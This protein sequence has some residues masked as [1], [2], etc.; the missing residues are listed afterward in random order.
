MKPSRNRE[1]KALALFV[2]AVMVLLILVIISSK[3]SLESPDEALLL[4]RTQE[5]LS[6]VSAVKEATQLI[7]FNEQDYII[8]GE[9]ARLKERDAAVSVRAKFL[10]R[11]K[12][13]T[14]D[15]PRNQLDWARMRELTD[16]LLVITDRQALLRKTESFAAAR[17]P[18]R[19]LRAR[20]FE[21][22][23]EI[24]QE[25]QR[26]LVR[27]DAKQEARRN[28]VIGGGALTFL[29]LFAVLSLNYFMM[30]RQLRLNAVS[31]RLLDDAAD[32]TRA[33]LDTVVDGIITID[34]RGIV[35]TINPAT[36][37][38]FGYTAAEIIGQNVKML[39]PEPYR[40]E[41]DG[42][43]ENYRTT[44]TARII[45]SGR[46]V[47]GRRKDGS[48]FPLE[49][50]VSP[51]LVSSKRHFTGIVHDITARKQAEDQINSFFEL[52]LDMMCIAGADGY[53]KRVNAAFTQMLGLTTRE[54]LARPFLDFVHADDRD[55]TSAVARQVSTG[56]KVM[57][58]EN[59]FLHKDGSSRDLSWMV[60]PQENGLMF[61]T[62]RDVT[63]SKRVEQTILAAKNA[64]EQAN[65][66]K[67]AFLS[68]MSHEIR[69]PLGGLLG[70]LELLSL[71]PLDPEQSDTL[72]TARN[73]GNSLLRILND[74]LDWSKIGEGKLELA[75]QA[76]SIAG[77]VAE[78]MSIYSHLAVRDNV[79]LTQQVDPRLSPAHMVD[80][81]RLAQVLNN[82][83]SNAIKFSRGGRVD[84]RAE[85]IDCREGAEQLRLS[86][87]DTGIGIAPDVQQRLF[88]FYGQG[89]VD[90]ASLYGGTGL[91]LAICHGLAELMGGCLALE[92]AVGRGS[93]FSI[94]LTL[95]VT[96]AAVTNKLALLQSEIAAMMPAQRAG[97][98]AE[99]ASAPSVVDMVSPADAPLIL[100]A[101][102]NQVLRNLIVCQLEILGLRA[103]TAEDGQAALQLWRNGRF[104]LV[105]TD[106]HM[107]LMDGFALTRAI[108]KIEADEA[109]ERTPVLAWSATALQE[110]IANS[111]S[112][113]IDEFMV[114]PVDLPR[115]KQVLTKWLPIAAVVDVRA[116][117]APRTAGP[118]AL[119][120]N[121]L[122]ALVG[123]DQSII[124]EFLQ[125][126]GTSLVTTATELR[127]ACQRGQAAVAGASAHKLKS[128][129]SCV[130]A[131]RLG[132]LCAEIE[133]AGET[134]D[135]KA[136]GILMP[137]FE[138]EVVAV[139]ECLHSLL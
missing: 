107:P 112:A 38:L 72:L 60:V 118:R 73:A 55:V 127:T 12:E 83:V 4:A 58:F 117:L 2:T 92:S 15:N 57:H 46:E 30:L 40:S 86:V 65:R 34:E 54:M 122:K 17:V 98:A 25:E 114:K 62:A 76:T 3:I 31:R 138:Q 19:E 129:A 7:V 101:E 5:L 29:L 6:N 121:V 21:I 131:P 120:V 27:H 139:E 82:F 133:R 93:T 28:L 111:R 97:G 53:F 51:T 77:L 41:H 59:R 94:T 20:L 36:E 106:Y 91:G 52:S 70:S 13:Q 64:A 67:N 9:V 42:Y 136:L 24:E 123:D 81:M 113:G 130:G 90:T 14:D 132:D 104:A 100:V 134:G 48:T 69:T 137:G 10:R 78:V 96:T 71:T 110:E 50:A 37:R 32:R 128:L 108:R 79:T 61:A 16:E 125:V 88:Q 119:D 45:G 47:I 116:A 103:E 49:L 66:S 74:I 44:G 43:L 22:L 35:D 8:S 75:P 80:P 99:A 11:I 95:P 26:V 105:I 33:I 87:S 63:E 39:M 23:R 135:V 1:L 84:I 56:E 115:L 85:L 18:I 102:D 126:F 89:S 124:A 68:A 109:R